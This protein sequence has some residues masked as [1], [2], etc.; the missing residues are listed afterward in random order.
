MAP[1]HSPSR[2]APPAA[3]HPPAPPA[4]Y[5]PAASHKPGRSNVHDLSRPPYRPVPLAAATLSA[6]SACPQSRRHSLALASS[7]ASTP[8]ATSPSPAP[9]APRTGKDAASPPLQSHRRHVPRSCSAAPTPAPLS[10][11]L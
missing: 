6:P 2:S 10:S 5:D 7:R 3:L 1:A 8:L 4:P 9:S 11:V